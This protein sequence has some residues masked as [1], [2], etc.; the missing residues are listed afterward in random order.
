VLTDFS[1]LHIVLSVS[2]PGLLRQALKAADRRDKVVG[3]SDCLACGPIDP[4][5]PAAR[6]RWLVSE[7]GYL[8][9]D[10]DWLPR[11]VNAFWRHASEPASRRIVWTSSRSA[12]E[13]C[14]FLAW[15]E[16]MDGQ[17]YD[18]VDLADIEVTVRAD[19]GRQWRDKA[20]SLGMLG[21]ESIAA[22]ALWDRARP[23]N[24]SEQTAHLDVW[25]RLRAENAPLR[26]IGPDGLTSAPISAFD[27]SLLS[28]AS[29]QWRRI[30][31]LIGGVLADEGP[32]FQ[33]G[34]NVLAARLAHL[35]AI[36]KLESRPPEKGAAGDTGYF[37]STTLPVGTEVRLPR[38]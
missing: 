17:Q 29:D 4:P 21:A 22:E 7:L 38:L 12:N 19:D 23:L 30:A 27:S 16:R 13:H 20:L 5:A 26:I 14:A 37:G 18:V 2:A 25:H 35:I 3:F 33:A 32:Y 6:L 8:R 10:W 31:R 11:N 36:G 28:H 34:D 24:P 1:T 15:V 9:E